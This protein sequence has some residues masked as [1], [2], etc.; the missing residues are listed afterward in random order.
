MQ[1]VVDVRILPSE[2]LDEIRA[3]IEEVNEQIAQQHE[4]EIQTAPYGLRFSGSREQQLCNSYDH[5]M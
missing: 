4:E 1:V 5:C 3:I 2:G